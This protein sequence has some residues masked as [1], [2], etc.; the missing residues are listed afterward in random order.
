MTLA[1]PSAWSRSASALPP[2]FT[3]RALTSRGPLS[4]R[5]L[6]GAGVSASALSLLA[7]NSLGE[8][9]VVLDGPFVGS[10]DV[11]SDFGT[12]EVRG[13]D[14]RSTEYDPTE[15]VGQSG[16]VG[17]GTQLRVDSDSQSNIQV[18]SSLRPVVVTFGQ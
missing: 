13:L 9:D 1:D 17:D 14:G 10:F 4:L 16:W 15:E 2:A 6:N 5:V 12:S 11:R 18:S 3:A 7:Q 8:V